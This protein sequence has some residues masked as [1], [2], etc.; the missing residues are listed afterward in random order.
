MKCL[1][2]LNV[3]KAAN[4]KLDG[5]TKVSDPRANGVFLLLFLFSCSPSTRMFSRMLKSFVCAF[6][7]FPGNAGNLFCFYLVVHFNVASLFPV[8]IEKVF[9]E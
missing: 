7:Y 8:V 3:T 6:T 4:S 2:W 5:E 1:S 9:S